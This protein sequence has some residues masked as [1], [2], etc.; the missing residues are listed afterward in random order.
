MAATALVTSAVG[1]LLYFFYLRVKLD[2]PWITVR[3]A[4]FFAVFPAVFVVAFLVQGTGLLER[5]LVHGAML[6][7]VLVLFRM[8]GML[9][10]LRVFNIGVIADES[11]VPAS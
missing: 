10:W 6:F 11:R 3:H 5:L 1:Y 8:I 4:I 2:L 7:A 9:E